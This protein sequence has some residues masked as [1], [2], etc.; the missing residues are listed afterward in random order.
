ML[1]ERIGV[2]RLRRVVVF[3]NCNL[4]G[5]ADV[6]FT[7]VSKFQDFETGFYFRF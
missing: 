3:K 1:R 4:S 5:T 6:N 2:V 7:P